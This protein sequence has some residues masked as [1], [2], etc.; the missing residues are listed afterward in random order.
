[1]VR[2]LLE[3]RGWALHRL[4][5]RSI[6]LALAWPGF[7]H[8]QYGWVPRLEVPFQT[9]FTQDE[10]GRLLEFVHPNDELAAKLTEIYEQH[11]T[12]FNEFAAEGAPLY[13][14][15]RTHPRPDSLEF[16]KE[17]APL[18]DRQAA[19]ER[20]LMEEFRA[21]LFE[22][23]AEEWSRFERDFRRRRVLPSLP[24]GFPGVRLNLLDVLEKLEIPSEELDAIPGFNDVRDAYEIALDAAVEAA[25]RREIS[26]A[27]DMWKRMA[28]R[29]EAT[30]QAQEMDWDEGQLLLNRLSLKESQANRR[31]REPLLIVH[32]LNA[33]FEQL[34]ASI[35]PEEHAAAFGKACQQTKYV[36]AYRP[37]P[38][39]RYIEQALAIDG[40]EP[41]QRE[42]IL[43]ESEWFAMQRDRLN[44]KLAAAEDRHVVEYI[45]RTEFT[46]QRAI[47]AQQESIE[48]EEQ[49]RRV[50]EEA[51]RRVGAH[52]TDHQ[53]ALLSKRA[54]RG[55][56]ESE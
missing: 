2:D 50:S 1:M 4:V 41:E 22:D 42:A 21:A 52:L 12:R 44:E 14:R 45:R 53:R 51:I 37:Q 16:R 35:M 19:M 11:Q 33:Q 10:F 25:E 38:A 49:L 34:F 8:A 15:A 3:W 18:A 29:R 9:R 32:L 6:V 5:A 24:P 27:R 26:A 7:A 43:A 36:R 39:D 17:M 28:E 23:H 40:L 46:R 48:L 20:R 56:A 30:A 31:D 54:S 13:Q 47:A 55:A